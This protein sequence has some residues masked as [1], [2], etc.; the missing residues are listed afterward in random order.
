MKALSDE[1]VGFLT[2]FCGRNF[3]SRSE[4]FLYYY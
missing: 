1:K 4:T 2:C 3:A